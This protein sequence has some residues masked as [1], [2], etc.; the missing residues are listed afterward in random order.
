M[1]KG[2][3]NPVK[4]GYVALGKCGQVRFCLAFGPLASPKIV[5][6]GKIKLHTA[7]AFPLG[8]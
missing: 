5:R 3:D 2:K 4:I 1:C 7:F 6:F 8:F